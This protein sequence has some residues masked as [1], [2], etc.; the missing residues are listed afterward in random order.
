MATRLIS[1]IEYDNETDKLVGFVLPSDEKGLPLTDS[2]IAVSFSSIEQSFRDGDVAK[3]V[4]VYMAQPLAVG[5]PAFSLACMGTDNKFTA[6][7]VLKRWNEILLGC[8]NREISVASFGADGDFRELSAMQKSVQLL[9]K[10]SSQHS[11]MQKL[12]TLPIPTSWSSW[13]IM[14]MH[15]NVAFGAY[16]CQTEV[17]TD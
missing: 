2:F 15:T 3:Y 14:K 11:P 4:F 10:S 12:H 1:R 6:D 9:T 17:Q 5:V 13:F 7:L 16:R 8:S